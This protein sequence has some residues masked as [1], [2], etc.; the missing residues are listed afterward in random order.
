MKIIIKVYIIFDKIDVTFDEMFG[1]YY[2]LTPRKYK[3]ETGIDI[4]LFHNDLPTFV[5][6]NDE[7]STIK[8]LI[9]KE[10]IAPEES[11]HSDSLSDAPAPVAGVQDAPVVEAPAQQKIPANQT[12]S[13]RDEQRELCRRM[14]NEGKLGIEIAVA[15]WPDDSTVWTDGQERLDDM[16]LA[17]ERNRLEKS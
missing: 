11:S 2:V 4:G 7:C 16:A 3:T 6:S 10:G 14:R 15:L 1:L 12:S 8:T 9:K 13:T 17:R 5:F